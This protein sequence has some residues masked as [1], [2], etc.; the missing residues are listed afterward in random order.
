V[1]L[2]IFN[3]A[4]T[5]SRLT[6]WTDKVWS[7][8]YRAIV[9]SEEEAAQRERLAYVLSHGA[10]EDLVPG[11]REWPGLHAVRALLDGEPVE[12]LWFDRTRESAAR[13]RGETFERD[14]FATP[15]IVILSPLPCWRH[16]SPEKQKE[17]VAEV[18]QAI[19]EET[20]ARRKRT[21]VPPLGRAAVLKQ[22]PLERP[23]K[24][25]RSAAPLFHAASKRVRD[26]LRAAYF[27]F[28]SAFREAAEKLRAG[29]LPVVFPAGSFPP[30]LPFVG[31]LLPFCSLVQ[32]DELYYEC[33]GDA[34]TPKCLQLGWHPI[35]QRDVRAR[36][37][38]IGRAAEQSFSWAPC[39]RGCAHHPPRAAACPTWRRSRTG[40]AA[41]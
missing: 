41:V 19:E 27:E 24:I 25:K 16:L 12:G 6:G 17:R 14:R 5:R 30:A 26:D 3:L 20:A 4:G 8:R 7:R 9:V 15:E 21:G 37:P 11:P 38:G 39:I 1:V 34:L 10:K 36:R 29:V 23:K 28:L 22:D 40:V 33:A 18:V 35:R 32:Y 31:G 13:R 2:E